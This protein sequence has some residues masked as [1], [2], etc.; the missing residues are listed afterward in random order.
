MLYF[1]FFGFIYSLYLHTF[2]CWLY[3][4]HLYWV[5][6]V[7]VYDIHHT[8]CTSGNVLSPQYASTRT[9]MCVSLGFSGGPPLSTSTLV[10]H[11]KEGRWCD[12][13]HD[14]L[15]C[16]WQCTEPVY[17]IDGSDIV[18]R[19]VKKVT[20]D[21]HTTEY[22]VHLGNVL[23]PQ[24]IFPRTHC[25]WQCTVSVYPITGSDIV[26]CCTKKGTHDTRTTV[27]IHTD[28]VPGWLQSR[29]D[30]QPHNHTYTHNTYTHNDR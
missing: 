1:I 10:V 4:S 18:G 20:W 23:E 3:I 5:W 29:D 21:T 26:G 17:S 11:S 22:C 13:V 9:G 24:H 19:C 6:L 27:Y 28:S 2:I 12:T 16:T 30:R 8:L 14:V 25:T 15:Y 7:H